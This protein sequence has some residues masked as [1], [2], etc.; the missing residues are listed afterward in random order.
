MSITPLGTLNVSCPQCGSTQ[1]V[2]SGEANSKNE[3][4]TCTGCNAAFTRDSL[5]EGFI[6]TDE[7]QAAIR[8]KA[9]KAAQE[10]IAKLKR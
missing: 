3:L 10:V 5:A 4:F 6:N 7:A 1:I 2:Q 8:E 9:L